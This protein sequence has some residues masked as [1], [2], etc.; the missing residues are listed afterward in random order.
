VCV[1]SAQ[2]KDDVVIPLLLENLPSAKEFKDAVDSM[3][4][5]QQVPCCVCMDVCTS[6]CMS[7]VRS[8][9][10][11]LSSASV[12]YTHPSPP[13]TNTKTNDSASARRSVPC[14]WREACSACVLFK[15]SRN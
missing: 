8:V 14:S 12:L 6:V 5:E 7:G 4:P 10:K 9:C 3:S 13:P 15:S 11:V 1:F 2:N